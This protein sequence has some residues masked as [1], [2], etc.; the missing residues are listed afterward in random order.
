MLYVCG[1]QYYVQIVVGKGVEVVF[2]D[3][4]VLWLYVEVGMDLGVCIGFGEVVG[5]VDVCEYRVV[6]GYFWIVVVEGYVYLDYWQCGGVCGGQCVGDV[7]QVF[8]V[9]IV[10]EDGWLQIYQQQG[11]VGVGGVGYGSFFGWGK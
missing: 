6:V 3:Q 9:L 5:M 11:G 8:G 4:Y 1:M 7:W 10:G 2:G